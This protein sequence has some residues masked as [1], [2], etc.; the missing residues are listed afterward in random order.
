[1]RYDGERLLVRGALDG[2]GAP[3]FLRVALASPGDVIVD[4]SDLET[5]DGAGLTALVVVR[6]TCRERGR[7]FTVTALAPDA[8]RRLRARRELS[9][10]F[11]GADAVAAPRSEPPPAPEPLPV[12]APA[13]RRSF[14]FARRH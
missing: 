2:D 3:Q 13:P 11:G 4:A 5:M 7:S 12:A 10:L 1:M 14:R 9:R 6:R 8:V